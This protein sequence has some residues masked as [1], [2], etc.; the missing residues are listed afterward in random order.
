MLDTNNSAS[1]PKNETTNVTHVSPFALA[2]NQG[3]LE[4][5][6]GKPVCT[7]D[8]ALKLIEEFTRLFPDETK[9]QIISPEWIKRDDE[10]H[11]F[12]RASRITKEAIYDAYHVPRDTKLNELPDDLKLKYIDLHI[13]KHDIRPNI[14]TVFNYSEVTSVDELLALVDDEKDPFGR[15]F[16]TTALEDVRI[17]I[18]R[19]LK[20]MA[21]RMDARSLFAELY[22]GE[23]E[24]MRRNFKHLIDQLLS[25]IGLSKAGPAFAIIHMGPLPTGGSEIV[26][27]GPVVDIEQDRE[28]PLLEN[29]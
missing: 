3:T 10:N 4:I 9:L 6:D 23:T 18:G 8:T 16:I 2:L 11:I 1:E 13:G 14:I 19:L 20:R 29:S 28:A 27:A 22:Q 12:S 21:H 5:R 26:K 24:T 7:L 15:L 25:N 17:D